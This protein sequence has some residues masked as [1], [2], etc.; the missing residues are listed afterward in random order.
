M[1]VQRFGRLTVTAQAPTVRYTRWHCVC[2]C[3]NVC[4]V[5]R[6]LLQM[7]DGKRSCGCLRAEW[8]RRNGSVRHTRPANDGGRTLAEVWR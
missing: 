5:S 4:I 2:D 8:A 1:I 6:N 3:G 7:R